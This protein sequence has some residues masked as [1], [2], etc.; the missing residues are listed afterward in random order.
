MQ[1]IAM[2]GT[3]HC[4][5]MGARQSTHIYGSKGLQHQPGPQPGPVIMS[6]IS[7]HAWEFM[8]CRF[9]AAR[10]HNVSKASQALRKTLLWRK[11]FRPDAIMF[12]EVS[13][14]ATGGRVE[15]LQDLDKHRRP[16][17]MYRLR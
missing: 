1:M 15:L 4:C 2:K 10:G 12:E 3:L 9:L 7:A 13:A 11:E 14:C 17:L 5:C 6:R 8:R 16:V